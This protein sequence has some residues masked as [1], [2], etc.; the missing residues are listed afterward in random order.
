MRSEAAAVLA[1]FCSV[2]RSFVLT[3]MLCPIFCV[4]CLHVAFEGF[5]TR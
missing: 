1:V 5:G 3:S 2:R 4:S